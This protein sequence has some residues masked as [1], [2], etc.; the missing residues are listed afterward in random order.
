[1]RC[2]VPELDISSILQFLCA[3]SCGSAELC[4]EGDSSLIIKPIARLY[5]HR[6]RAAEGLY[7]ARVDTRDE[8]VVGIGEYFARVYIL[9]VRARAYAYEGQQVANLIIRQRSDHAQF[10]QGLKRMSVRV[11]E[12]VVN[13]LRGKEIELLQFFVG[14]VVEVN[15]RVVQGIEVRLQL[16]VVHFADFRSGIVDVQDD[17]VK[18]KS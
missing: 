14:G 8:F 10:I 5:I 3:A 1:M 13:L 12:D 16:F 6:V 7:I 9:F 4:S 11:R 15:R 18:V 17:V 2:Y